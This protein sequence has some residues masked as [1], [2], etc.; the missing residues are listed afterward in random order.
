MHLLPLGRATLA[1]ALALTLTL[2]P[3]AASA[4]PPGGSEPDGATQSQP[5]AA[6]IKVIVML[7]DQ[8]DG[9]G[10]RSANEASATSVI[11]RLSARLS[12][13]LDV[14]RTF[15]LLVKGFSAWV[16]PEDVAVL[17][18][19]PQ[20]ASVHKVR[21]FYPSDASTD[22]AVGAAVAQQRYEVDGRGTVVSVID[23]GI[24]IH[25]QDMR[26]DEGVTGR[27]GAAE[28]F[29]AKVPWGY[30]FADGNSEVKD[31]TSSQHGMHVAGIV[32][33]NGG[34]DADPT[35]NG[36][37]N[38]IAPNAQLL[39]M[40]VFSNDPTKSA[41]AAEDDIIAAIEKSVELGADVIN[42]SLGSS[43]GH[44]GEALG[45]AR[46]VANAIKAGVQV[47]VAAGNEGVTTS[48]G[49]TAVPE[50]DALDNGT[51]GSPASAPGSLA[52]A[53]INSTQS[54]MS[55]GEGTWDGGSHTFGYDL[56]SG[57]I[58]D[59]Q[60]FELVDG[61][62]GKK[63][64]IPAADGKYVLI[65]RG[66]ITFAEKFSNAVAKGAVGVIV[67]NHAAGGNEIPG[68]A[69]LE[70]QTVTGIGIGHDDGAALAQA[71]A[72]GKT[73][74]VTLRTSKQ[75][76]DTPHALAPSD[77]TSWGATPD[78]AFKPQV[79]GIG[80]AVY[81]TLNDNTYGVKS[82]TSMATPQ[83]AGATALVLSELRERQPAAAATDL[84]TQARTILSNTAKIPEQTDGTPYAPRRIGA[85]LIQV[86]DALDTQ[87]T[88]TVDGEP[89]V[90]LKDFTGTKSFTVTLTNAGNEAQSFTTGATCVLQE[91]IAAG[92]EDTTACSATDTIKASA[93]AVTVPAGGSAQVTYTVS[94]GGDDHWTEGWATF[95][96]AG[97]T[98]ASSAPD[99]DGQPALAVPYLGFAGNWNA[100]P[101][102]DASAW[103]DATPVMDE[104]LGQGQP[105]RT[106]LYT[107]QM[108]PYGFGFVWPTALTPEMSWISPN[109]DA[110]NDVVWPRAMML[111]TP[112][113]LEGQILDA[114]G[115]VVKELGGVEDARRINLA[116]LTADKDASENLQSLQFDGTVYNASATEIQTLP[117]GRYTFRLRARM[118]QGRPWQNLDMPFGIDT[119]PP[120]ITVI[121]SEPD[122]EQG[123]RVEL[124]VTDQGGSGLSAASNAVKAWT[125]NAG[126]VNATALENGHYEIK[127]KDKAATK[128]LLLE[129]F[130]NAY[131]VGNRLVYLTDDLILENAT[132]YKDTLTSAVSDDVTGKPLVQDG[133][134]LISGYASTGTAQVRVTANDGEPVVADV[135]HSEPGRITVPEGEVPDGYFTTRVPIREGENTIVVEAL[136]ADGQVLSTQTLT[137]VYDTQAPQLTVTSPAGDQCVSP[138]ESGKV[139]VQGTVSDDRRATPIVYVNGAMVDVAED[140]SFSREVTIAPTTRTITVT[141]KDGYGSAANQA[142]WA[143]PVCAA[144]RGGESLYT[145][146]RDLGRPE[147]WNFNPQGAYLLDLEPD[148][149]TVGE[150]GKAYYT[151][152]GQFDALPGQFTVNGQPVTVA[153]DGSFEAKVPLDE[154]ISRVQ[155][156]IEDKDG[157]VWADTSIRVF[158]DS[159]APGVS[160]SSPTVNPDGAIYLTTAGDVTFSGH[161][162]DNAFGY[163]LQL[164]G[165][166]V[167]DLLSLWDPGADVT[168]RPF[169]TVIPVADGDK[170]LMSLNDQFGNALLALMPVVV[171]DQAPT[172]AVDGVADQQVLAAQQ[173]PE[174]VTVTVSDPHLADATV[175]LDGQAVDTKAVESFQYPGA[176]VILKGNP[177]DSMAAPATE[178]AGE[179][180]QAGSARSTATSTDGRPSQAAVAA[181]E[182]LADTA[183]EALAAAADDPG[184]ETDV[185]EGEAP[186]GEGYTVLTFTVP[187][188]SLASGT[189]LL[190]VQG[191]DKAGNAAAENLTFT[192]DG[193]P[194]LAG[195]DSLELDRTGDYL[196]A[197]RDAFAASDAEDEDL[198]ITVA[199]DDLVVGQAGTVTVS[200]TDHVGNRV[201]KQVAVTW[202][203]ASVDEGTQTDLTG[204]GERIGTSEGGLADPPL[205]TLNGGTGN[206]GASASAGGA[207]G[208]QAP[209]AAGG[210]RSLARAERL[211]VTGADGPQSAALLM[212]SLGFVAL[213]A[214]LVR[215][216]STGA[217]SAKA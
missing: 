75:A 24:D 58:S 129:A 148:K 185:A 74:S 157:K 26:L 90:A 155:V 204:T 135:N 71:L 172:I 158:Y 203:P 190:S 33:A 198:T 43:N 111:R 108:D 156:R 106:G 193:A 91:V 72:D 176:G 114:A 126:A 167:A 76:V 130:D 122:G 37:F 102:I 48:V 141:A 14:S 214:L 136:D 89:A 182:E 97:E 32:A 73:V 132:S 205:G 213:G 161:V 83:V 138:D 134:V 69:G 87:V 11:D 88:A 137:F 77:F 212:V 57:E 143:R 177:D 31:T 207:S 38:G 12:T 208:A 92:E 9:T 84:D 210:A 28:G 189:H 45:E 54:F 36:R 166:V 93:S 211:P 115:K 187:T 55:Q 112:Q 123:W 199:A 142:S 194:L 150:D 23:S 149:I 127:V 140:G 200:V 105:S 68:M 46:A 10:N 201:D 163:S 62:I 21:M 184:S 186:T 120:E 4:A 168:K 35:V 124:A 98:A 217:A 133:T 118:G 145:I 215:R 81:S 6:K 15:G 151:L 206:D 63:D 40:K 51:L 202:K 56:Q 29:T 34:E 125:A 30:N 16:A 196:G 61:G 154:G 70:D 191:T 216:R 52:V 188:A 147:G 82:G 22:E 174:T 85:G 60:A 50:T 179:G 49:G 59:G 170:V 180:A 27:M 1:G 95:T 44:D 160:F 119:T 17:R 79:A 209:A 103:D 183:E 104:L 47:V 110:M 146:D 173:L 96:P 164:N 41:G 139:L 169:S 197:I 159:K 109:G 181:G 131:A 65:E 101:I 178:G 67:Y 94:V 171:D 144:A 80:G 64:Q 5:A 2:A 86:D 113:R 53:S 153:E 165:N 100:E 99:Q 18:S 20:V 121:T 66:E 117:D 8:P 13:D 19:D 78:L 107:N 195:P 128:Y 7:K 152:T 42:M 25:H 3:T 192:V 116:D 175:S 162:W 39:A